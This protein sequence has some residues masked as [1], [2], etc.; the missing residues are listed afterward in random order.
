MTDDFDIVPIGEVS[1]SAALAVI[2]EA[3]G[4]EQTAD[5]Y[6]WKHSEG[7][8]GPS[9]GA[10]A[11]DA[12]G[13]I[14]VRLLLPWRFTLGPSIFHAHRATEAATVP[15]AQGRGVFSALNRWMMET[16]ESSDV[17]FST[18]NML[19]RGGY[20]KLG[21]STL[22]TVRW[23]WLPVLPSVRPRESAGMHASLAPP[24]LPDRIG[25]TWDEE[26]LSWR[27]DPRSR[28]RYTT[29][30]SADGAV[31][32]RTAG[33]RFGRFLVPLVSWGPSSHLRQAARSVRAASILLPVGPGTAYDS[34][35]LGFTRGTSL[36]MG[37]TPS[38]SP[39]K[40]DVSSLERWRF[41][42]ADLEGVM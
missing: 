27:S 22:G 19:S 42:A 23:Q 38:S 13:V 1:P 9:I 33:G 4:T 26:A 41:Y 12:H 2:N 11:V 32:H 20:A 36:L 6:R 15:R 7:P 8:W 28:H 17:I 5:W 39:L 3:F 30:S 18:P 31:I 16:A 40:E 25:T 37:W 35:R 10:A 24:L 34:R 29:V 21:W 14:G